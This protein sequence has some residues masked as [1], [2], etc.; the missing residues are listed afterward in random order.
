MENY[1]QGTNENQFKPVYTAELTNRLVSSYRKDPRKFNDKLISQLEEHANH[2]Q[3]RFNRNLEDEEFKMLE[4]VKQVG[5]GFI[6]GFTTLEM[7]AQPRNEYENIARS[8]G[9]LGGFVGWIPGASA[10]SSVAVL[11][12]L[13]L[14]KGKSVPMVAAKA[15]TEPASRLA[16]KMVTTAVGKRSEAVSSAARLLYNDKARDAVE[17]AFHLGSASAVSSWT[18][19][20]DAMIDSAIHGAAAGGAGLGASLAAGAAAMGPIGWAALAV[21]GTA[22]ALG[23]F[24]NK[25]LGRAG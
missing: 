16:S 1:Q 13:A 8:L 11:R 12:A 24:G 18:H 4:T 25:K 2:Y 23:L 5:S 22:A 17:G 14:L 3:I 9:H 21:G 10:K 19:G 6:S 20:I 7:G 15:V